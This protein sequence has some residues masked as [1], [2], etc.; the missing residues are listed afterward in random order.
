MGG[1]AKEF[2]SLENAVL[3]IDGRDGHLL[4]QVPGHNQ[5]VGS[6]I[7]Q[8]ITNDGIQDVFIG[9]RSAMFKAI[10]GQSG[11]VLWEFLPYDATL[12][13]VNDTTLLNFF[14]PQWVDDQDE[15]G[16]DDL[17]SAYGGFVKARPGDTLRPAGYLM[18][19]SGKTGQVIAKAMVTDGKETYVS[20]LIHDFGNGPE[21]IY[22]TGGEDISGNLYRVSLNDVL[23]EDLSSSNI[24]ARGGTKGM[25]APPLLTDVNMDGTTDIVVA[26][27]DGRVIAVDGRTNQRIW[28]TGPEG[29]FDTYVMPAPGYFYGDDDT[30]DFFASFGRGAWPDTEFTVHTLIDGKTGTIVFQDTLGSFQ[31][32]SPVVA[33]F[34]NDGRPDVLLSIN[35]I[36]V[37]STAYGSN[38]LRRNQLYVFPNG[39]GPP[40]LANASELG[41]NLGSTPLLTDLD[42]D[43]KLDLITVNMADPLEFYSF[44]NIRITRRELNLPAD[45]ISFGEYMGTN[46]KGYFQ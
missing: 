5:I 45:R 21:V 1:A 18:V 40:R 16:Y 4:W 46:R 41:T 44:K 15:D 12:D 43:G 31:Y 14:T 30:P 29:D 2:T 32:A 17:L 39:Q 11:A 13:Y 22:G 42:H 26:S 27:V 28:E 25:I 36:L 3:A 38:N 37:D 24:V 20:P 6:A 34:T 35:D 33:D 7:L 23:S 9:G 10:D 19:L 8:D